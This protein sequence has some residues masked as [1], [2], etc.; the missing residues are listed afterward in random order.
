MTAT[1]APETAESVPTA[2]ERIDVHAVRT[3]EELYAINGEPRDE[4]RTK[5]TSYL[6]PL[7]VEY[8]A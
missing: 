4:I 1:I 8:L 5:H 7:L 2:R 6:T 3:V